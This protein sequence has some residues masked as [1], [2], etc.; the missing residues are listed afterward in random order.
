MNNTLVFSIIV[1]YN[2]A[3]WVHNCF[4][5]LI[6]STI[7]NH[8]ILAIDNGSTDNTL[9]IIRQNYPTIEIIETGQN[10]GFGKANNIGMLKA[11]ENE[12]DYV[13]LL[14][15]DAWIENDTIEKLVSVAERNKDFGLISPIHL[16]AKEKTI[17]SLFYKYIIQSDLKELL[18]DLLIG[19]IKEIYE[20]NYVNAAAWLLPKTTIKKVGYFEPLFFMY[21]EDDNY[22]NRIRYNKI[23]IGFTLKT[24]IHHDRI[25]NNNIKISPQKYVYRKESVILNIILNPNNNFLKAYALINLYILKLIIG[26]FLKFNFPPTFLL[27][28]LQQKVIIQYHKLKQIRL[29]Y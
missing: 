26:N 13:F 1:T 6:N 19:K 14:N 21:G 20:I 12:A 24:H 10:L 23:K 15:Q 17:D 28:K 4:G 18:S 11:I 5:S 22:I 7:K 25:L 9:E 29:K 2:G 8:Q 3:Q 16:S 27:I